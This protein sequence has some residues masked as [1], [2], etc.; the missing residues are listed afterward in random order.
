MNSPTSF[1]MIVLLKRISKILEQ[2]ITVRLSAIAR[3]TGVLR[4]NHCGSLPGLSS[5]DACLALTH[6]IITLLRC[7][8]K[9]LILYLDIKA[10]FD[11][12]NASTHRARLVASNVPSYLVYWGSSFL[13]NRTCTLVFQ[14]YPNLLSHVSVGTP[15]AGTELPSPLSPICLPPTPVD[16]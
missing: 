9:V 15:P 1:H 10:G 16:S 4:H 7:R 14:G 5:S 2:V 12:L 3:S 13:S 11:N 8:L 6:E